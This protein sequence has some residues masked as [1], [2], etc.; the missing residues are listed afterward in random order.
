MNFSVQDAILEIGEGHVL[1]A[2]FWRRGIWNETDFRCRP[3]FSTDVCGFEQ[4]I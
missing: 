4:I 3:Y 1:D 2:I